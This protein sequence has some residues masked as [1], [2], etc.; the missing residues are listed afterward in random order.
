MYY[1][2]S[3]LVLMTITQRLYINNCTALLFL[4]MISDPADNFTEQS[5]EITKHQISY[6]MYSIIVLTLTL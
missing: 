6:I 5:Q 4:N 2:A 3:V 1:Y